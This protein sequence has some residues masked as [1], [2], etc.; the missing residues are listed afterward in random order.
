MK[1]LYYMLYKVN[2][3][4]DDDDDNYDEDDIYNM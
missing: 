4:T 2:F 3:Y 1:G